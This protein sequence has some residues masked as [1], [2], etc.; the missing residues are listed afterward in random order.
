MRN[1]KTHT[2]VLKKKLT[3]CKDIFKAY[4]ELQFKYGEQLERQS[5][6]AEIKCNI[7]IDVPEL[8][9]SFTTDFYCVKSDGSIMVRECVY[10]DKLLKPFYIKTLDASRN[11]WLSKGIN[12]WGLVLNESK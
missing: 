10:Q 5:N 6:I 9:G 4:S 11:Y 8:E 7:P 1:T 12:D 3:K 2:V